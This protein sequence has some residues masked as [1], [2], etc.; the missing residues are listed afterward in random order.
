[1]V[2][3]LRRPLGSP[4][5][6]QFMVAGILPFFIVAA[7]CLLV[8]LVFAAACFRAKN[9]LGRVTWALLALMCAVPAAW[10]FMAVYPELRD[11]RYKTYRAFYGDIQPGMSR[12]ELDGLL[13]RHYPPRGARTRPSLGP[14]SSGYVYLFMDP[15]GSKKRD[16]MGVLVKMQDG[17]VLDKEYVAD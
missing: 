16:I 15:E 12:A 3:W 8:M 7:I 9:A 5:L 13:D 4:E 14:E 2:P 11:P 17:K 10:L 1:M 6:F